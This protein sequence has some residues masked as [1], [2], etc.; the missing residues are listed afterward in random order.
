M[1][2]ADFLTETD[3]TLEQSLGS[4]GFKRKNSKTWIRRNGDELNVVWL[5]KHSFEQSFCVNLGVHYAFL[6]KA[7]T[8]MPVIG[9]HIEQPDCEI[10]L[11]LTSDPLVNDQWWTIDRKNA[12]EIARLLASRGLQ[13]FDA[14][15]LDGSISMIEPTDVETGNSS[16]L[17]ALIKVRACLLLARLHERLGNR[18][19]CVEAATAGIKLAIGPGTKKALKDILKRCEFAE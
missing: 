13:I 2:F 12:S 19:R 10:K 17:S 7:G 8:E 6:P 11:R 18:R 1:N 3:I 4:I 5:Q 14:Y 9:D 16:L 15:R